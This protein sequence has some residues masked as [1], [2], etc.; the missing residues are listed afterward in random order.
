MHHSPKMRAIRASAAAALLALLSLAAPLG[1][2]TT[3]THAPA[4]S[5]T[6]LGGGGAQPMLG[7]GGGSSSIILN[8]PAEKF[9]VAPGGVDMRTMRYVYHDT[10]LSI[11]GDGDGGLSLVR[12][13]PTASPPHAT[14]PFGNFTFNWDFSL[15][16][17]RIDIYS[18]DNVPGPP[19]PPGNDYKAFVN[20][21]GRT[22]T[23]R[24]YQNTNGY[25]SM[26][27]SAFE[28]LTFTLT[29]ADPA[30]VYTFTNAQNETVTFAH[31][32]TVDGLAVTGLYPTRVVKP[33]GTTITFD[34]TS[35]VGPSSNLARVRSIV[36]SRGY[37][38]LLESSGG[39]VS[40]ACTLNLAQTPL[41]A[42][43]LCP[44]NA[45]STATYSYSS[46]KLTSVTGP[47]GGVSS[48]VYATSGGVSTMAFVRPGE[49][50][51]WLTNTVSTSLDEL[52][53]SYDIVTAQNFAD[54]ESYAY[55]A[56]YTPM[57]TGKVS[58]IAGGFYLDALGNRTTVTW[59]FP[60][61]YGTGAGGTCHLPPCSPVTMGSIK[62]QQTSGPVS[63]TDPLSRTT[64]SDYCDPYAAAN[65][66]GNC[67]VTLLQSFTDAEGIKTTLTYDNWQ[68]V[69][70]KVVSPKS[71]SGLANL[72]TSATYDCTYA[73]ACAKPVTLTDPNGNV[74]SFTYDTTH[75]GVLTETDPADSHGVHPVKRYAYVQRYAWLSD[76]AGGYVHGSAPMWLLS[77]EKTC[78]TTAT[79]SGACAGGTADEVSTS[80]DYGPDSG[81]NNL[82]L[83]GT[84]VTADGTTLRT[85]YG[86]D[87]TGNKISETKPRANLSVCP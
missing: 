46:G 14:N 7:G 82:L 31:L 6:N 84:A 60:Q 43:H 10:D 12:T 21:D 86:Y 83:R 37:A 87:A 70:Q 35:F 22:H 11:G 25:M 61:V 50:S 8:N 67:V 4:A 38:I 13:L 53:L 20:V 69:T 51:P 5:A 3:T 29:Q 24:G 80:Y 16:I 68:N 47:D 55:T 52:E 27:Q 15:D 41:P 45:A 76:G 33:D 40:K 62:Y 42:N 30:V 17:Y 2:Q 75:G 74:T 77:S 59:G 49:T 23:F 73:V 72:T 26:S 66:P 39:L 32:G 65:Q 85:C 28:I 34:Y 58:T 63:V 54:G 18:E 44:S 9:V 79:V 64:T 36:S 1:A 81:P 56:K 71:G 78:R 57:V 48:F 19:L